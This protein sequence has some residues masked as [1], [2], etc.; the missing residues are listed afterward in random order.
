MSAAHA[1][2]VIAHDF[3][4]PGNELGRVASFEAAREWFKQN[5]EFVPVKRTYLCGEA[6]HK[7]N[8]VDRFGPFAHQEIA[9]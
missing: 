1:P 7:I 6:V 9:L 2:V 4:A 3:R 5:P 8:A